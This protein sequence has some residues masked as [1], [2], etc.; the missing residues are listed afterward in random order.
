MKS[1]LEIAQQAELEPIASL[2]QRIGLEPDEYEPYGRYK[3]KVALSVIERLQN[4][5]DG[6]L[7]CVTGMTPTAAGVG[8]T[9]SRPRDRMIP[10]DRPVIA[11]PIP[12]PA[13]A[14]PLRVP[15]GQLMH[16]NG[17]VPRGADLRGAIP[18]RD[19]GLVEGPGDR[20]AAPAR[21]DRP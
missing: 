3:A 12:R 8:N 17:T 1:S 10:S 7:I 11:E 9:G 13:T 14:P 4:R 2:A 18:R 16:L 20:A 6:K 5:P 21:A 19:G 15:L